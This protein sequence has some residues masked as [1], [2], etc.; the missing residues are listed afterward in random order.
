[1]ENDITQTKKLQIPT[2]AKLKVYWDDRPENYSREARNRVQSHFARKYGVQ[3]NNINVVFR[4]TKIDKNG[5]VIEITGAGIDN[6]MDINYQRELMKEWIAREGKDV[7]FERIVRLDEKVNGSLNV[8]LTEINHRKWEIKW[9]AVNNFLC[10]GQENYVNFGKL[11]GL[12]T[13]NSVPANQG[14]KTT[15]SVDAIKFLLFGK[16]SKTDKNDEVFNTF[17]DENK[18]VVRGMLNYDDKDVIIER[19][20]TRTGKRVGGYTVKNKL[21]YY[22]LMPDGS[23]EEMEEEDAIAT[24]LEIKKTIGDEEDFDITILTTGKNLE[25]LIDTTPTESGKLLTKFIGIEVIEMKEE[26][27]RKM[28]NEYIKTMKSNQY[29]IATL[30]IEI[31]EHGNVIE[32]NKALLITQKQQLDANKVEIDNLNTKKDGF[33]ADKKVI[34]VTITQLNPTN[35]EKEIKTITDTGIKFSDSIKEYVKEIAEIGNVTYDEVSYFNLNKEYNALDAQLNANR[36]EKNG[37]VKM[38]DQLKNGEICPTC[39]RALEDVDHSVEIKLEEAKIEKLDLEYAA[40][41]TKLLDIQAKIN[42]MTENKSKVDKKNKLELQKDRA[43]VEIGALRNKIKE[44]KLD[45]KKYKDNEGAINHNRAIDAEIEVVKTNIVVKEREKETFI[46]S[47]Q[48]TEGN[49]ATNEANITEKTSLIEVIKKELEVDRLFKIYVE[50]IG[51]KGISKLILRSVL[52]IINS[53]LYRLMEDVCDFNIE[54]N[55]NAK[56]D[57][58]FTLTKDGVDKKLKSGSGVEKTISSIALRCVLGKISHLPMPNFITFDEPFGA[59]ASENLEKIKPLFDKIK[60]MYDIV[61]LISHIDYVKDWGDNIITV[62]KTN[63]ISKILIK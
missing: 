14:G 33:I 43:E 49:I 5:N 3:K 62:K 53:E 63:N 51:K 19:I 35:I 59:V 18:T 57:V 47:I 10:Y 41:N 45:L 30:K 25:N 29:N 56:N 42:L 20:L 13:I 12:T 46:R 15:F 32:T 52:P 27:A 4:P 55:I 9:L 22:K 38:V 1:M 61:F 60:D 36:I 54:L 40:G 17:T 37:H 58:E 28:H 23:E 2:Y 11:R 6:I 7:D 16:T 44:K 48:T 24:T 34:D 50:M 21:N 31:E 39:K 26:I 8:D